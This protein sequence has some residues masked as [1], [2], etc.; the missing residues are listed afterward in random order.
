MVV[1]YN[2][3]LKSLKLEMYKNSSSVSMCDVSGGNAVMGRWKRILGSKMIVDGDAWGLLSCW[4]RDSFV[5]DELCH[6]CW[7]DKKCR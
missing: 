2:N 4:A 5:T 3:T 1:V 7:G 6:S